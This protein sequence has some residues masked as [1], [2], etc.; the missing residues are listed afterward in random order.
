MN[1]SN[2][3]GTVNL[4]EP[5]SGCLVYFIK[6]E[7]TD[8]V[9]LLA[10]LCQFILGLGFAPCHIL[11]WTKNKVL[12]SVSDNVYVSRATAQVYEDLYKY[13]GA[14]FSVSFLPLQANYQ[15]NSWI[16][17]TRYAFDYLLSKALGKHFIY[18]PDLHPG[19]IVYPTRSS[20]LKN[21]AFFNPPK[22]CT[23]LITSR[24]PAELRHPLDF[25]PA[26]LL[27]LLDTCDR[28][29]RLLEGD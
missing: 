7:K 29:A 21:V 6:V 16:T 18:D 17:F 2:S 13:F 19:S 12:E 22:S 15:H 14:C 5:P 20:V 3:K 26:Q 27:R 11:V 1:H 8:P 9:S 28:L 24:L 23:Y 4:E 10:W 25:T